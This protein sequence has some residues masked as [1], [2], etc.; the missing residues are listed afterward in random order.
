M[1]DIAKHLAS[2]GAFK[3]ALDDHI[4]EI[5]PQTGGNP[6]QPRLSARVIEDQLVNAGGGSVPMDLA[7]KLWR[8]RRDRI[9]ERNVLDPTKMKIVAVGDS[10]YHYPFGSDLLEW[11]EDQYALKTFAAAG[12]VLKRMVAEREYAEAVAEHRPHFFMLSGAGNDL[13]GADPATG[14]RNIKKM[15]IPYDPT[16]TD[17]ITQHGRDTI[18]WAV[19]QYAVIHDDLVTNLNFTGAMVVHGYDY[20]S[21]PSA[22]PWISKPLEEIGYLTDEAQLA[23]VVQLVDAFNVAIKRWAET[24]PNVIHANCTGLN[25]RGFHWWFNE[26][27]PTMRGFRYRLLQ[28]FR[29]PMDDFV[30][31]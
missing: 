17:G 11:F 16:A 23:A 6:F 30:T 5:E 4:L 22:G 25:G 9:F 10:W 7:N 15:V 28:A 19:E 3:A 26:I 8:Q 13:L 20:P 27:H 1:S 29:K 31:N 14:E 21:P 18:A 2:E 12:D 24:T